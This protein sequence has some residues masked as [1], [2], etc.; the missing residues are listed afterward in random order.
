MTTIDIKKLAIYYA[1][2][3]TVNLT[4]SVSGASVVFSS[5]DIVVFGVGLEETSHSDHANTVLIINDSSMINTEV[6]GFID[7]TWNTNSIKSSIDKWKLMGVKG[8]LCDCFGY[9]CGLT[10]SKQNTI[11]DYIHSKGLNAMVNAWTP[12][13]VFGGTPAHNLTASDWYLAESYQIINGEYQDAT[14]WKTKSD[15]MASYSLTYGTKM[16][17]VTT[18]TVTTSS[19]QSKWDYAYYSTALYNFDLAGWGEPNY[20]ASTSLLPWRPRKEIIGNKITSAISLSDPYNRTTNVGIKI[21]TVNHTVN[22][23]L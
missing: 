2:P 10:R 9:D 13:D 6:Y 16:A 4:Y 20:S 3:S 1:W 12:D 18:A 7:A 19:D 14:F 23:I 11:V 15:K 5:Y 8:I 17:T 22:F 21:D